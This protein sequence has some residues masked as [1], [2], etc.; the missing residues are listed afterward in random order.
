MPVA[1]LSN[2][3][4]EEFALLLAKGVKQ[5]H[6]YVKAG[7]TKNDPAASR[8]AKDPKIADRVEELKNEVAVKI[9][10]A[11][12]APTPEKWETLKDM[13][14]DMAWCAQQYKLIYEEALQ[15]GQF[16]PANTAVQ[17]IQKIVELQSRGDQPDAA[18]PD[19]RIDINTL[20]GVLD[21]VANIIAES[22]KP[23]Q[24]EPAPT[25][26]DITPEE[27]S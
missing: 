27:D 21:K 11:I 12:D 19:N 22:K 26:I 7:Y 8:L 16:A 3:K 1:K 24:S 9:K 5:G 14:I 6:A 17:N 4:H 25:L 20:G 10:E 23:D 18:I 13:G 15:M 2:P